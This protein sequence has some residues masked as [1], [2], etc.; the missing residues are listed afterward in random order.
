MSSPSNRSTPPPVHLQPSSSPS[1]G[2]NRAHRHHHRVPLDELIIIIASPSTRG[3][4]KPT[5]DPPLVRLAGDLAKNLTRN[6]EVLLFLFFHHWISIWCTRL[7]HLREQ[8][9]ADLDRPLSFRSSGS[10]HRSKR[11]GITLS[12]QTTCRSPN[13]TEIKIEFRNQ[14][15]FKSC[16]IHNFHSVSP[17]IENNIPLES[18]RLVES[19]STIISYISW[20]HF[21]TIFKLI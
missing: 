19:S 2:N 21:E 18:L 7:V 1:S 17:K 9:L 11:T 15:L 4:Q 13:Q 20:V 14:I 10:H 3:S 16:K 6:G 5:G 8:V 12:D